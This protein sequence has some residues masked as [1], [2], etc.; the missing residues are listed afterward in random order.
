MEEQMA[1]GVGPDRIDI[2]Y[3]RRG[4]PSSPVVLLVMGLAAQLVHWPDC[5]CDALVGRGLQIIRFDNRDAGRSTHMVDAPV[6]DLPA[7]M[8]GDRSSVSYT[9]SHM[10]ADAAGLLDAL[11]IPAAHVAGA[12]MGGAIAQMMAIEYPGRVRSLTSM[13]FTTGDVAVGQ[14]APETLEALFGGPP[15]MTRDEVVARAVRMSSIVGSP[16]Y[17]ADPAT[18]AESAGRAFDRDH[19]DMAAARQAVATVASGDRTAALR[20]L[21]MPAL[22]IHGLDDR[23]CDV[24]GGRATAAAIP[25]A[26]LLLIEGMGHN[27]PPALWPRIADAIAAVVAR[28]EARAAAVPVRAV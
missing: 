26:E 12:S 17:P 13:M 4:D 10:A 1:V 7:V 20:S 9:L 6:P 24:S 8:A 14:P 19:D 5:F 11:N 21:D 2:A 16:G 3:E 25:G 15:A 28:G 22:V 27:L 18:V 23:M